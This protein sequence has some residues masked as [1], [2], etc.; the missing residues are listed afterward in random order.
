MTSPS[1]KHLFPLNELD[2][3][4]RQKL[5]QK[6]VTEN[7]LVGAQ[8]DKDEFRNWFVYLLEGEVSAI[9]RHGRQH[10]LLADNDRFKMPL[11]GGENSLREVVANSDITVIKY[12]KHLF[13]ILRSDGVAELESVESMSFDDAES[14]I[15]EEIFS[16]Y[17]DNKIELP[18]LPDIAVKVRKAVENVNV[19][20]DDV[21]HIVEADPALAAQL[22]KLANSVLLRAREPILSTR[23]A[24]LRVGL[25]A[26]R[27]YV[28]V[29]TVRNLFKTDTPAIKNLMKSFYRHSIQVSAMCYAIAKLQNKLIPEHALLAGLLHDIGVIPILN[30]ASKLSLN[31]EALHDLRRVVE[32]LKP[33]VGGMILRQWGLEDSFI[34]AT[35]KAEDWYRD[36]TPELQYCDLVIIAQLHKSIRSQVYGDLP[37]LESVPVF[38]KIDVCSHI[39]D[40]SQKILEIAHEEIAELME[41]LHG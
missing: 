4:E 39:E 12:D 25:Q 35:E 5:E 20:I 18:T 6:A 17:S 36:N 19:S 32:K 1:I 15:F 16:A 8:L 10:F 26:T 2:N 14:Q 31:N 22:I 23:D 33:L 13:E 38:R 40:C 34:C 41:V 21:A 11:F 3:V 7:Y 24:V 29:F 37:E 9:D 28:M 30:Y 27:D